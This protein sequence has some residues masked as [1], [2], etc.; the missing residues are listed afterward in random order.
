M[1]GET[2]TKMPLLIH[3]TSYVYFLHSEGP[4]MPLTKYLLTGDNYDVWSKA[5]LNALE[6]KHK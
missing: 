4:S 5:I 1:G 6:G 3:D 2:N